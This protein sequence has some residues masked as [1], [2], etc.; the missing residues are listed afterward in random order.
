MAYKLYGRIGKNSAD[1]AL[2]PAT[3]ISAIEA[4]KL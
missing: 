1:T 2:V 3:T 4:L